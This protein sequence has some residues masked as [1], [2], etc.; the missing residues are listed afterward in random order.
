MLIDN[1]NEQRL[2]TIYKLFQEGKIPETKIKN[3]WRLRKKII[4]G[5]LDKGGKVAFGKKKLKRKFLCVDKR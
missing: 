5:W 2:T 1:R 4:D 3:Q